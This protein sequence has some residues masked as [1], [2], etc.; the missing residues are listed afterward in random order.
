MND[1][2]G[3]CLKNNESKCNPLNDPASNVYGKNR[4]LYSDILMKEKK[5]FPELYGN[6]FE[7]PDYLQVVNLKESVIY[8]SNLPKYPQRKKT[9]PAPV[10]SPLIPRGKRCIL[11]LNN[12]ESV[13]TLNDFTIPV[14]SNYL[15]QYGNSYNI[16][17]HRPVKTDLSSPIQSKYLSKLAELHLKIEKNQRNKILSKLN[18]NHRLSDGIYDYL[19]EHNL[20]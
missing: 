14:E 1:R 3:I 11:E 19:K 7:S 2:F 13:D 4:L 6:N 15:K 16:I 5:K 8:R 9:C 18:N 20:V 10:S 17:N 12:R